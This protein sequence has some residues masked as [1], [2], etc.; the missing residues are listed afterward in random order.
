MNISEH[1][2][3]AADAASA[4]NWWSDA[5]VDVFVED[6]PQPW[7]GRSAKPSATAEPAPAAP[8]PLPGALAPLVAL[9]MS[10]E[11]LTDA[12]PLP[13]RVAP[14]GKPG[15]PLMILT[16][17]PERGDADAGFLLSGE[18]GALFDKML[19]A[20]DQSR[21]SIYFAAL[22]PGRTPSGQLSQSGLARLRD[23]ALQH[24]HLAAPKRVWL[25][26]QTT[27]RAI[28]GADADGLSARLQS[29]NYKGGNV[30][31]V[32]SMHPRLLVQ[33]PR[34]KAK[35]WQDMKLLIG[36]M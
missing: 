30:E 8:P 20:I 15:S 27:S 17:M 21:D 35:V 9:L 36:G 16:D 19:A 4:L 32:A 31:C 6:A 11:T 34:L 18:V 12:G 25:L 24:I 2:L 10:D 7:L 14:F 29:I 1:I 26:G 33:N 13:S 28:L 22:C 23:L 3:E 5:G